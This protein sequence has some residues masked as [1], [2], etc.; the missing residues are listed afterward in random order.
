M[1]YSRKELWL[2]HFQVWL[3]CQ[4]I[5]SIWPVEFLSKLVWRE[6]EVFLPSRWLLDHF[7]PLWQ[8][9]NKVHEGQCTRHHQKSTV[10]FYYPIKPMEVNKEWS[11]GS[12]SW[13]A[14]MGVL[15][16]WNRINE[17]WKKMPLCHCWWN[18]ALPSSLAAIQ[19]RSYLDRRGLHSVQHVRE[20]PWGL[21]HPRA[22][23]CVKEL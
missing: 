1:R 14:T 16:N 4:W 11:S 15:I 8:S 3:A 20:G 19:S 12:H 18:Q 6:C 9:T 13:K 23:S 7:S 5:F 10:V 2:P 21:D 17:S 22:V